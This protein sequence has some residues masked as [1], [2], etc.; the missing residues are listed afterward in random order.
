MPDS[1]CQWCGQRVDP[2]DL[3]TSDGA[4]SSLICED[5]LQDIYGD[6][7]WDRVEQ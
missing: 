5:C 1:R 2:R 4:G 7:G 3:Y 6:D